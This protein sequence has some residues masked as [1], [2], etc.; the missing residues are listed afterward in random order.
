MPA[1]RSRSPSS[2]DHARSRRPSRVPRGGRP[3]WLR[4][5]SQRT[6]GSAL[7]PKSRQTDAVTARCWWDRDRV[8][9]DPR[10]GRVLG[11]RAAGAMGATAR[12]CHARGRR[13]DGA[14]VETFL[15]AR[16]PGRDDASARSLQ[17]GTTCATSSRVERRLTDP[18]RSGR[19]FGSPA[20]SHEASGPRRDTR[21]ASGRAALSAAGLGGVLA[22]AELRPDTGSRTARRPADAGRVRRRVSTGGGQHASGARCGPARDRPALR[23]RSSA[24]ACG[25]AT[26]TTVVYHATSHPPASV[27]DA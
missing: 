4:A 17:V 10:T 9:R 16:R 11:C 20:R 8:K 27:D 5:A 15:P 21:G 26:A 23:H 25:D 14:A 24:A 7:S 18:A 13:S 1:A 19:R 12:S 3:E 22:F 2:H 6:A